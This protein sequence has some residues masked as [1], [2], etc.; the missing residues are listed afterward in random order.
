MP[1]KVNIKFNTDIIQEKLD[2]NNDDGKAVTIKG[3]NIKLPST[4]F[5]VVKNS[6]GDVSDEQFK[7]VFHESQEIEHMTM[8]TVQYFLMLLVKMVDSYTVRI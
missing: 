7:L 8:I 1:D 3:S 2:R 4:D 5:V 6:Y